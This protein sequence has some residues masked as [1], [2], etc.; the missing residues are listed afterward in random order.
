M[1]NK[2][3]N[4]AGAFHLHKRIEPKLFNM[5]K[6]NLLLLYGLGAI[7]VLGSCKKDPLKH[8]SDEE[9][10]IY[11]TH[12]DTTANFSSYTTFSV[13]DS[14]AIIQNNQLVKK[15]LTDF[16]AAVTNAVKQA[17]Q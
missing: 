14:V 4:C 17:L 6:T 9:T 11:I 12:Y 13:Q 2:L 1:S 5:E 10:R 3:T 7:V 8:L 16:D 15:E